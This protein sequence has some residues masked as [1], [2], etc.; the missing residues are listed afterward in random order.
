MVNRLYRR[1]AAADAA[2]AVGTDS[3]TSYFAVERAEEQKIVD[4][5]N[6]KFKFND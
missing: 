4:R 2:G 3:Y 5:M 6:L 1:A